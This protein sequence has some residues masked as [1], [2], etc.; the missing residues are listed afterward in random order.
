MVLFPYKHACFIA[1]IQEN[2][3]I[4]IMRGTH[5][6]GSHILHE[7]QILLHGRKRKSAA[8]L[9]MILMAAEALNPELPSVQQDILPLNT[10]LT[11][12]C[13][14]NEIVRFPALRIQQNC[15]QQI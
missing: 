12:A 2:F 8:K 6:I 4:G 1:Q 3:I 5:G 15:I 7:Q 9:G 10:D 14:I 13:P 11:E